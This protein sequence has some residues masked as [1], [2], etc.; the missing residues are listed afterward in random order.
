MHIL[1]KWEGTATNKLC[2][3]LKS[4]QNTMLSHRSWIGGGRGLGLERK[5]S[6]QVLNMFQKFK[7]SE[8][9]L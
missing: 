2:C 8:A 6:Q 1:L 7:F 4:I 5:N 3:C 9:T